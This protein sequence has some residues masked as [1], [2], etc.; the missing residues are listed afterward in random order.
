M[1]VFFV[2]PFVW[3]NYV[4]ISSVRR[5]LNVIIIIQNE[6][7]YYNYIIETDLR[8]ICITRGRDL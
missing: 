7:R 5:G 1:C 4:R 6:H 2:L 8:I 3:S